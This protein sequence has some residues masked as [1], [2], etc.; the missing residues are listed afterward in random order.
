M[1][2]VD[3]IIIIFIGLICLDGYKKGFIKTLFDTIGILVAFFVSKNFCYIFEDF[4]LK[5]TKLFATV[6]DFF[7]IKAM[8]FTEILHSS[9]QDI[10][11]AF[12]DNLNLPIELQ[13]VVGNMFIN[14]N[15]NLD[16]F[17]TF[18]D[19][20][21]IIIVRSISFLITFLVIYIIL[22]IISNFIN[23]LFKLPVLNLA[24]KMFGVMTGAIKS[25]VIL[26]IIFALC[27][28]VIGFVQ[29]NVFIENVLKSESSKIFYE[30]NLILNYLSY[31]G[32]YEN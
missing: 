10:A 11:S 16:T 24:N 22:V 31:K 25:V 1:N 8:G 5:H 13:H 19:N 2:F 17:S 20:I 23:L 3:I 18:V 28:P 7:E 6:H 12:R 21:S 30:N 9:T 26:Y 32:F 29:G 27:S 15:T 14:N 4:L